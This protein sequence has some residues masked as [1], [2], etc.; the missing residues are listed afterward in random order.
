MTKDAYRFTRQAVKHIPQRDSNRA[1]KIVDRLVGK[2]GK[3]W[4]YFSKSRNYPTNF[5]SGG[6]I[7]LGLVEPTP[8][9]RELNIEDIPY[10]QSSIEVS[11]IRRYM[12]ETAHGKK[13]PPI[14]VISVDGKY[15]LVNGHHRLFAHKL[16]K[17]RK[18]RAKI[19]K[20]RKDG[21]IPTKFKSRLKHRRFGE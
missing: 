2:N 8:E 3:T 16:L 4:L 19:Y 12:T 7:K 10:C 11:R 20:P 18:I 1:Q 5:A 9:Y 17:I 21:K 14:V 15:E 6:E 13:P